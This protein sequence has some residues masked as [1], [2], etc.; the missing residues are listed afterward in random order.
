LPEVK[1]VTSRIRSSRLLLPVLV[2]TGTHALAEDLRGTVKT[3][4]LSTPI[5]G[6]RVLLRGPAGEQNTTT[7]AA[8]AFRFEG[9]DASARFHVE[10]TA[11]MPMGPT[12]WSPR[13]PSTTCA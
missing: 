10:V 5:G 8:G 9:L 1:D 11:Q 7:D 4:T 2:L 3:A 12:R 6:A 13:A